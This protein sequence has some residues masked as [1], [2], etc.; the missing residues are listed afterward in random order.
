MLCDAENRMYP[1]RK[2]KKAETWWNEV[3]HLADVYFSQKIMICIE[4]SAHILVHKY[5]INID[6]HRTLECTKLE[7]ADRPQRT[8]ESVEVIDGAA[9]RSFSQCSR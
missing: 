1:Y 5:I 2:G 8:F 4:I 9:K 7:A 3:Y 6:G